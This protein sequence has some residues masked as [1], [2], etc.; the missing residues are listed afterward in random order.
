MMDKIKNGF[1]NG[2][3]GLNKYNFFMIAILLF[4]LKSYIVFNWVLDLNIENSMQAFILFISP[5]SSALFFFGFSLFFKGVWHRVAIIV[6]QVV[7]TGLLYANVVYGRF[8]NDF[9]TFADIFMW[10][11]AGDLG[12]STGS[13]IHGFDFMFWLDVFAVI[14]LAFFMKIRQTKKSRFAVQMTIFALAIGIFMVNLSLAEGQRSQL[15]TRAFDR[16]KLVK[17]LGLYN[18]HV[19]DIAMNVKASTQKALADSSDVV[20]VKNYVKAHD[21]QPSDK[22]FG[23]AKNKNVILVSMESTQNFLIDYKLNGKEVTPFLNDLKD[24]VFYFDNFYHNTGQGKTS[25]AEFLIDNSLYPL[26]GGSVFMNYP[27]NEYNATPEI[28]DKQGYQSVSFH[29]NHAS[30]WN[31]DIMYQTLGYDKF[32]SEKYFNMKPDNTLNYGLKDKPFVKQAVPMLKDVEQPFYSKFLTLSNHFPFPLD[33]G[34]ASIEPANTNDGVVNRYFQ[35]ARYQDEALKQFFQKLKDAGIYDDSIIILYGDHYGIS[36]NHNKAMTKIL[37]VDE[38]TP[39]RHQQLQEVPLFIHIPGMDGKQSKV[40]HTVGGQIDLKST[41]LNL[42]GVK[43]EDDIAFGSSLFSPE[44]RDFTIFRDGSFAT[45]QYVYSAKHEICY[46]KQDGEKLKGK[47]VDIK[48]C[49]PFIKE[50]RHELNL[51]DNVIFGDLLRF[52]DEDNAANNSNS[53]KQKADNKH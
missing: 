1:K 41:I 50:A 7:L 51:S 45:D 13:L 31:R 53:K 47:K 27:S 17:L 42:L 39:Y 3:K 5:L 9:L 18:Y 19:Y 14:A 52:N 38:I 15:L 34:E 30:F 24:K 23:A 37:G 26:P 32:Y 22:F 12:H 35:T 49:Q 10:K 29:G 44:H 46:E 6:I 33:P 21:V 28:L 11:N 2:L 20:N 8:F 16:A 36:E 25:D 48:S 40:M 43:A 4:W